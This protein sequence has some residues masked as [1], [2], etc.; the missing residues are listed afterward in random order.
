M[1]EELV[2]VIVIKT[3]WEKGSTTETPMPPPSTSQ[4]E[5]EVL[6]I[7]NNTDLCWLKNYDRLIIPFLIQ[8]YISEFL[9]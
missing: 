9:N 1:A 2:D 3:T 5:K 8:T 7:S 4:F 6:D